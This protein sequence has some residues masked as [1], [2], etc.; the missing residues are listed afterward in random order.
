MPRTVPKF[1]NL[2]EIFF[3][4]RKLILS[5]ARE[6]VAPQAEFFFA[7]P[8]IFQCKENPVFE[9]RHIIWCEVGP[10]FSI[11]FEFRGLTRVAGEIWVVV[12]ALSF[13]KRSWL[14][15][16]SL[17]FLPRLFFASG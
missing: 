15:V 13:A 1:V 7:T 14:I 5:A 16:Q 17:A 3:F 8:H 4:L 2:S 12:F 9:K 11:Q 6:S 10:H